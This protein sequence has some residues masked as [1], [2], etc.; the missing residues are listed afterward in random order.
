MSVAA[1][2]LSP[3]KDVLQQG[4]EDCDVRVFFLLSVEEKEDLLGSAWQM[5]HREKT[6]WHF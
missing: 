1:F 3:I 4:G 5:L 2:A 6:N